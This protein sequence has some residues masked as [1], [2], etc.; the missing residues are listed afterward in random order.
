MSGGLRAPLLAGRALRYLM[1]VCAALGALALYVLSTAS[2]NTALFAQNYRSLLGLN[3]AL[4]L[5]LAALVVYQLA[6]LGRRL[7]DK[8][9]GSRLTLRFVLLF[10]LLA[11]LPGL[12]VYAVSVQF[13]ER[14]IESWFEVRIDAALEGGLNL[15]RNALDNMLKD[16]SRKAQTMA[17]SLSTYRSAEPVAEL[18][19]LREQA[20]V[21]EATLFNARGKILAIS[22]NERA[23]L[24]PD[25]PSAAVLRQ[26]RLQ[27]SYSAIE[28]IPDRGLYL[29]VLAP[30]VVLSLSEDMR[31]LQLLQPVPK[32]LAEDAE[33]VQA[34]YRDYQELLLA[35]VGLKRLYGVALTLA[36]VLALLSALLLAFYLSERLSA[37][38]NVLAQGTRAVAQ[39]DFSQRIVVETRD[40]LGVLSQSFNTMTEQLAEARSVAQRNQAQL[41]T[42]KAYLESILSNLSAGVLAFDG[43]YRLRSANPSAHAILGAGLERLRD[44]SLEHWAAHEPRLARVSDAI[45]ESF[46]GAGAQP[47]ERQLE[48]AGGG[49]A[50][51]ML[52]LRGTRLASETEPGFVV[53]FDDITHL[54]QAQRDAAWSE[55]ARRLA[56]EIKNPLTPIQLS[57][58]RVQRKLAERLAPADA[59]VLEHATR[60]IVNQ[61]TALKGMVDAFSQYAKAPEPKLVAL[62]LNQLVREV[63]ALYESMRGYL[64][65]ELARELPPVIG[66]AAQLRQVIH[67]L[68]QNAQDA[69]ADSPAPRIVVKSELAGES[70]R[71]SIEDNGAGFPEALMRRVFEPYVTTKPKGTGL[72]LVIVKKIIEEHGGQVTVENVEPHGARVSV[73]LARYASEGAARGELSSLGAN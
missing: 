19:R 14:S 57:A 12:L 49:A 53:V 36:L 39:G 35:R 60:T 56:H 4:L 41:E 69:L 37:P 68:L 59:E 7:R 73:L 23:P 54:L 30:V 13:L 51:R 72:G 66:D 29:R 31:V 3:V 24:M 16:V 48:H 45:R 10:G 67:N 1:I 28:A 26:V 11:V 61:V 62:D 22:G 58:E 43:D 50:P 20:D 15:G 8:V 32:R 42:A 40:E 9:F 27:Q 2:A 55:V 38:L 70:V 25:P 5:V 46:A 47:W 63:L 71:L 52:L 6:L 17:L 18:N 44:L 33:T 34:G 65:T 64:R 21:Q